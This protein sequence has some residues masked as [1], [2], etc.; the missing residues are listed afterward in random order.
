[1]HGRD[2]N[3]PIAMEDRDAEQ[4]TVPESVSPLTDEEYEELLEEVHPLAES[5]NYRMDLFTAAVSFIEDIIVRSSLHVH[6]QR[7]PHLRFSQENWY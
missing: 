1:M 5:E 4:V 3:G 6:A 2:W 7:E